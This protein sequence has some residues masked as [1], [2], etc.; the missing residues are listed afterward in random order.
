MVKK[1]RELSEETTELNRAQFLFALGSATA[2]IVG[3]VLCPALGRTQ[4]GAES[5]QIA[6]HPRLAPGLTLR[7]TGDGGELVQLDERGETLT[8]GHLND[9]GSAVVEGMDGKR[10]VQD[11]ARRIHQGFDPEKLDETE[12][13]VALFLVTLAQ[14]GLLAEPFYVN[15]HEVEVVG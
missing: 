6:S 9:Y 11:L 10:T 2:G 3:W 5:A 4:P 12:A 1:S 15:V 7:L 8:V 14:A 13:S